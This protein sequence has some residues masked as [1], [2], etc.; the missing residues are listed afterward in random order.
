[1]L[2]GIWREVK[3]KVFKTIGADRSMRWRYSIFTL[4]VVQVKVNV[5][6]AVVAGCYFISHAWW[7]YSRTFLIIS[8]TGYVIYTGGLV[9]LIWAVRREKLAPVVVF[10]F[11]ALLIE[12]I[13]VV[14]LEKLWPIVPF[15]VDTFFLIRDVGSFFCIF[16]AILLGSCIATAIACALNFGGGLRKYGDG[17]SRRVRKGSQ[18]VAPENFRP[19]EEWVL[20]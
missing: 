6:F 13:L 7:S 8:T 15:S 9:M 14:Q 3:W 20:E 1:M 16:N 17:S 18:R 19:M 4:L 5:Y 11:L 12:G 10:L 2:P